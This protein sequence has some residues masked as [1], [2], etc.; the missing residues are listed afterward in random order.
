MLISFMLIKKK[1]C[2]AIKYPVLSVDLG[3]RNLELGTCTQYYVS[4]TGRVWIDKSFQI[5][6]LNVRNYSILCSVLKFHDKKYSVTNEIV[7]STIVDYE[8]DNLKRVTFLNTRILI[9]TNENFNFFYFFLKKIFQANFTLFISSL[10]N[11][12]ASPN[13]HTG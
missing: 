10:L 13:Y 1:A 4:I 2:I 7:F 5:R 3:C 9:V 12:H 8:L 11:K 6:S